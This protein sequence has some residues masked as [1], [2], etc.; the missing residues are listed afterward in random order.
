M[1]P[2]TC[3]VPDCV[4]PVYIDIVWEFS[5]PYC[6]WHTAIERQ[7][8]LEKIDEVIDDIDNGVKSSSMDNAGSDR[9]MADLGFNPEDFESS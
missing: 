6:Q 4:N 3:A 2:E 5:P 7:K 9:L 1:N 8:I